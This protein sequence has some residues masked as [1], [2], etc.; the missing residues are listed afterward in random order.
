MKKKI[1][2]SKPFYLISSVGGSDTQFIVKGCYDKRGNKIILANDDSNIVFGA[3]DPKSSTKAESFSAT[4]IVYNNDGTQTISGITRNLNPDKDGTPLSANISHGVGA[5]IIFSNVAEFYDDF[6]NASEDETISGKY[7]FTNSPTSINAVND[8]DLITKGQ[9]SS[10]LSGGSASLNKLISSATAGESI[11]LNQVVYLKTTDSKWYVAKA[12][13][14]SWQGCILGIALGNASVNQEIPNG[15]ALEGKISG[16]SSLS[17]GDV[18]MSDTGYISNTQG[19]IKK[20]LGNAIDSNNIIFNYGDPKPL[21]DTEKDGIVNAYPIPLSNTNPVLSKNSIYTDGIS[22]QQTLSND[23]IKFGEVDATGKN[24]KIYQS[25]ISGKETI[26]SIYF[27]KGNYPQIP[28]N[29]A[30]NLAYYGF[31]NVLT[32]SLGKSG[33]LTGD[34]SVSFVA[35]AYGNANSARRYGASGYGK[36]TG[37]LGTAITGAFILQTRFTRKVAGTTGSYASIVDVGSY[38]GNNGFALKLNNSAGSAQNTA[39]NALFMRVNNVDGGADANFG[40]NYVPPIDVP[41]D[42]KMVY[43]GATLS[44]YKKEFNI[45]TD[46][47]LIKSFAWTTNPTSNTNLA[48]GC[49][50]DNTT[51][52]LNCS[53]DYVAIANLATANIMEGEVL[54]SDVV[55]KIYAD[56]AGVPDT[57]TTLSTITIPKATYNSII[58]DSEREF[59][60]PSTLDV[61][62]LSTYWI[63]FSQITPSN[64]LYGTL[65]YQNTNQSGFTLKKWNT[66]DTFVAITG[67]LYLKVMEDYIGKIAT[68]D[69]FY[70][71]YFGDGSDG[72]VVISSNTTLTRDMFY[73]NLTVNTGIKLYPNGYRIFVRDTLQVLG[74]GSIDRS[75]FNGQNGYDYSPSAHNATGGSELSAGTLAGTYAGGMGGNSNQYNSAQG[76]FSSTAETNSIGVKGGNGGA[77]VVAGTITN[78]NPFLSKPLPIYLLNTTAILMKNSIGEFR[79]SSSGAGGD[80]SGGNGGTRG[81]GGGGSSGGIIFISAKKID[82]SS[83]SSVLAKGGNGGNGGSSALGNASGGGGGSGGV[84][85]LIYTIMAGA[86]LTEA[87][88][89]PYGN[90]GVKGTYGGAGGSDG[91]DGINGKIYSF[92]I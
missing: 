51:E 87:T 34:G 42:I 19:T 13:S 32:D 40:T 27:K 79:G 91:S 48:I 62:Y 44:L 66:T 88:A 70:L 33:T 25:F 81:G 11:L 64:T 6:L 26:K 92:K 67:A 71:D 82:F 89:T 54:N 50:G 30:N 28:I 85:V 39:S 77:S 60:L 20:W 76:G 83:N 16:L 56:N 43:D 84:I 37:T 86:V 80:S 63:E 2:E 52:Y 55:V 41:V 9:A 1:I 72:D 3:I 75:G 21:K 12:N 5:E 47:V 57:G 15:V 90:K 36:D 31:S 59:A 29:T 58:E 18:Y 38:S 17:V 22:A 10:L 49:R 46:W 45:D 35:D 7:N 65:A 74:T 78:A 23:T 53:I 61:A 68:M 73:N 14:T 69:N 8:E 4:K 24:N